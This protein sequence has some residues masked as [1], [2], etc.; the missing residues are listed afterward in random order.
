M[1]TGIET[2]ELQSL[3]QDLYQDFLNCN[4]DIETGIKTFKILVLISKLVLRLSG[5][6]FQYWVC[7]QDFHDYSPVSEGKSLE[8]NLMVTTHPGG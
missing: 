1:K 6:E 3:D 2:L 5:L 7:Y 8:T 4:L